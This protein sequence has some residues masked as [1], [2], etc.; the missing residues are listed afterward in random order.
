MR[1]SGECM[2][3]VCTINDD[4]IS[5][6]AIKSNIPFSVIEKLIE[7]YLDWDYKKEPLYNYLNNQCDLY[8]FITLYV[9][10][11][12]KDII[13]LFKIKNIQS[14]KNI[15][16]DFLDNL[17]SKIPCEN[18]IDINEWNNSYYSY[19]FKEDEDL[20]FEISTI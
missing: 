5:C 11:Y 3:K 15:Y 2:I 13:E 9:E 17:S 14:T 12:F 1:E 19:S 8:P 20:F 6:N 18:I 16:Y 4:F 10:N 7:L